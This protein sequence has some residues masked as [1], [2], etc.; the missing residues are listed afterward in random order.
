MTTTADRGRVDAE[1]AFVLHVY[2]FRETS[3]IIE[4]LS[5]HHGRIALV[6]RGARRPKSALRGQLM[7][8]QPL[9]LG[10][11]GK[12]DLK[13]LMQ[14]EWQPG[15]AQLT[16]VPLLSGFYMNELLLKLLQREDAHEALYDE[17]AQ[18]LARLARSDN[19]AATLRLFEMRLLTELGY[20]INLVEE[21]ATR[22]AIR[23]EERYAF[24]P[25]HGLSSRM[26]HGSDGV[27][28]RG[29]TLLDMARGD[30]SDVVTLQ[31]A[32]QLLR[33]ALKRHLGDQELKTR[34]LLK[35]L[36]AL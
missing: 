14:V 12:S 35:D 11:S 7:A 8:F 17:Y 15:L 33:I 2:P 24:D 32:K 18:A 22:E 6:G 25:E 13:L 34:Q 26:P 4:A 28:F 1:P 23:A 36:Q 31:E 9:L 29:K 3:L 20:G 27:Q 19:I 16:G 21:A 10:W 5:R 30:F